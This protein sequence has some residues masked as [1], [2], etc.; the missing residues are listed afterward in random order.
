[1][2]K[3]IHSFLLLPLLQLDRQTGKETH[4]NDLAA[5]TPPAPPSP[6]DA[7]IFAL[8]GMVVLDVAVT[9]AA[10]AVAEAVEAFDMDAASPKPARAERARR[11]NIYVWDVSA[12]VPPK[13]VEGCIMPFVFFFF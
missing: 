11:A 12:L 9:R 13:C 4:T 1:M 5:P 8:R 3:Y 7:M 10:A 2:V 6:P